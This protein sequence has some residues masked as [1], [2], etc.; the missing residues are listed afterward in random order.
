MYLKNFKCF[1]TSGFNPNPPSPC[2]HHIWC[3]H[4][5]VHT[6]LFGGDFIEINVWRR[7]NPG[8]SNCAAFYGAQHIFS[9]AK[10]FQNMISK[11]VH[12]FGTTAGVI[13]ATILLSYRLMFLL[14]E[15]GESNH[16]CVW[17]LTQ[18]SHFYLYYFFLYLFLGI[19]CCIINANK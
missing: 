14:W 17:Q 6:W 8:P 10:L 12:H 2:V 18:I 7:S 4:K 11:S 19:R 13:L 1:I 15:T 16:F 5:M 9:S 3:M